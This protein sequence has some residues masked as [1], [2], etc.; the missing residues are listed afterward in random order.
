MYQEY[1]KYRQ[2]PKTQSQLDAINIGLNRRQEL[3]RLFPNTEK[4]V[5]VL[6]YENGHRLVWPIQKTRQVNRIVIHHTAESLD[7]QAS[8]EVYLRDIYKYH[9]ITRG[10]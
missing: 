2:A 3:E 4:F 6:R 9:A 8:D 10:W 1:L 5:S 7:K